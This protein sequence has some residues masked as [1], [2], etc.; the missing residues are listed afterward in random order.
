MELKTRGVLLDETGP[1]TGAAWF[2]AMPA[3]GLLV[4]SQAANVGR[5]TRFALSGRAER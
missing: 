4:V 5:H 3:L 1:F 2:T